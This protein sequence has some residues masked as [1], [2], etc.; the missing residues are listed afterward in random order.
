[1]GT[2][3]LTQSIYQSTA[4]VMGEW[5]GEGYKNANENEQPFKIGMV[6]LG[7]V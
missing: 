6:H 7:Q 3:W 4:V 1:M 5:G 2:K